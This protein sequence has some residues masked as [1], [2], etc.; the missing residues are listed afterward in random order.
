MAK[1]FVAAMVLTSIAEC[2]FGGD[3]D[4][5]VWPTPPETPRVR[6]VRTLSSKTDL[7]QSVWDRL[8]KMLVGK[9]PSESLIKPYGLAVDRRGRIFVADAGNG[10]VLVF[11]EHPKKGEDFL[12]F[13]GQSGEGRLLE[14]VCVTVDGE[15]N[16]YVSDV[17]LSTIYRFG[18]DLKFQRAYGERGLFQR[19]AGIAVNPLNGEIVVVDAKAH[20]IRVFSS[21]G[22]LVRT[23]GSRGSEAGKFNYPS[24][25]AIDRKGNIYIV[26]SM[27]FRI[28]VFDSTGVYHHS[29]GQA[30]NV[31]GS[32]TRPKGIA[33]DSDENIYVSDA[34]FDNIQMFRPDGALLLYFGH[35]GVQRGEFQLP[36]GIFCDREDRIYV[37]DQYNARV[38]VFQY[39]KPVA[40]K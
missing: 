11:D 17:Q 39:L 2:S 33:I 14:P 20:N 34:A 25:V 22:K 36:A 1:M 3:S 8:R 7:Q 10:C 38:Q 35:A 13:V 12:G 29:F 40:K 21:S 37:A 24:N 18:S 19:P 4:D 16:I 5:L 9:E 30:D 27:N 15:D 23:F 32:F 6:F 28:Q 31:P 26:D